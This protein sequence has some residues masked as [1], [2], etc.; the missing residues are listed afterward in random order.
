MPENQSPDARA[1]A[2]HAGVAV[3]EGVVIRPMEPGDAGQVL[4]IYQAGLD[5]GQ[6][7][8]E[9]AAPAWEAFDAAKL[10][11]GSPPSML[12]VADASIIPEVPSS[13]TN[14]TVIMLA[15]RIYQRVYAS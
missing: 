12:R 7:S 5:T 6:A 8:F 1:G 4:T 9:I 11:A 14:V 3:P 15:E 13:T 2:R 10:P